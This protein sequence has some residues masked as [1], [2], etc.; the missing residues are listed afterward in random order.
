MSKAKQKKA[1]EAFVFIVIVLVILMLPLLFKNKQNN[2]T[3]DYD[4]NFNPVNPNKDDLKTEI[5]QSE[6]LKTNQE[7]SPATFTIDFR[8][9]LSV[10]GNFI[11]ISECKKILNKNG[12]HY[13][14]EQTE[15][16]RNVLYKL[17]EISYLELKHKNNLSI[18]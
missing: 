13:S 8:K 1:L 12:L 5:K 11:S 4:E 2:V 16:V 7:V 14:D 17:A 10:N 15:L 18:S 9:S 6:N 3:T